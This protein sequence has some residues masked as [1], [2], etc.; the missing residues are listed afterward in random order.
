[1]AYEKGGGFLRCLTL[2]ANVDIKAKIDNRNTRQEYN[3]LV[4]IINQ[5]VSNSTIETL[6]WTK[7]IHEMTKKL[8]GLKYEYKLQFDEVALA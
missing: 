3:R 8:Y 6:Y 5:K 1:M 4:S 7:E 2:F